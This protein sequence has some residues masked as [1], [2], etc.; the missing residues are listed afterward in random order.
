MCQTMK[1]DPPIHHFRILI[2]AKCNHVV[3]RLEI[4]FIV[5]RAPLLFHPRSLIVICNEMIDACIDSKMHMPTN[6]TNHE[7][8]PSGANDSINY[9]F[10]SL[11]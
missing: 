8:I 5:K 1:T 9:N 4:I 6:G 2:P 3:L 7:S 10:L 11:E